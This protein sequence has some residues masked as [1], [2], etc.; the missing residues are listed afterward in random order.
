MKKI[1]A[2]SENFSFAFFANCANFLFF[3][4]FHFPNII[5]FRMFKYNLIHVKQQTLGRLIGFNW[6]LS[7]ALNLAPIQVATRVKVMCVRHPPSAPSHLQFHP[8]YSFWLR[9]ASQFVPSALHSPEYLPHSLLASH[10]ERRAARL[11]PHPSNPV[12]GRC[13]HVVENFPSAP[14]CDLF[15]SCLQARRRWGARNYAPKRCCLEVWS[16]PRA[17]VY[18]HNAV[19]LSA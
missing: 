9:P 4:S 3:V 10:G 17:H 13:V 7:Y 19:L 15:I 18:E 5:F 8:K 14:F 2:K 12:H 6:R 1:W 16:S 11:P